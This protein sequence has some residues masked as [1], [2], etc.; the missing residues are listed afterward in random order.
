MLF[1]PAGAAGPAVGEDIEVRV[2]FTATDFD[3]VVISLTRRPAARPPRATAARRP[4]AGPPASRRARRRR[5]SAPGPGRGTSRSSTQLSRCSAC[6]TSRSRQRRTAIAAS[7]S[8]SSAVSGGAD[9]A[10]TRAAARRT[11]PARAVVSGVG[12]PARRTSHHTAPAARARTTTWTTVRVVADAPGPVRAEQEPDRPDVGGLRA[13][14]TGKGAYDVGRGGREQRVDAARGAD[15]GHER[16]PPG[17]A[18]RAG[19]AWWPC[20]PERRP[21]DTGRPRAQ[22]EQARPGPG[23]QRACPS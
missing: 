17:R 19:R 18:G 2:R 10:T 13:R 12:R 8:T 5:R 15:R 7:G 16:S 14:A 20:Q 23:P 22:V 21:V 9:G 6:H 11:R 3:R 1:L 4:A